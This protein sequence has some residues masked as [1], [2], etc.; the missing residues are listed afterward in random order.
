MT[1]EQNKALEKDLLVTLMYSD[2]FDMPLTAFE[3]WKYRM[4]S[5]RLAEK[6]EAVQKDPTSLFAVTEALAVLT[7]KELI[8]R[9]SGMFALAGREY[10]IVDRL[11]RMKRS[12]QKW[13]QFL[14]TA[15]WMRAV[16]FVRMIAVTGRLATKQIGTRSDWDVLVVMESGHIWMGRLCMALLLHLIGKRRYGKYTK[17][18]VCLN[19]F[20]TTRSLEVPLKDLFASREYASITPVF[21]GEIFRRF[22]KKNKWI[23]N[24]IPDWKAQ[25]VLSLRML[26]DSPF[27]TKTQR[28]FEY[29][30]G[31]S[32]LEKWAREAQKRKIKA[33]PK[34]HLPGAYIVADDNALIF[35]PKPQGPRVFEKFMKRL[36]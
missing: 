26:P 27:L 6:V 10:L 8:A 7:R 16:P 1:F 21:G 36:G 30:F 2:V 11:H 22:E 9:Q 13:R 34:T 12:D 28:V 25:E 20:L 5:G 18:R 19:H 15:R 33:N 4:D 35:L 24:Y 17:D 23:R 14:K 3:A 31:S 29:I 32:T